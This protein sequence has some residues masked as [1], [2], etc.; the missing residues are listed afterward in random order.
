MTV[1]ILQGK[2]LRFREVGSPQKDIQVGKRGELGRTRVQFH[3]STLFIQ[4]R[5]SCSIGFPPLHP[6]CHMSGPPS[7][8]SVP[9]VTC[10]EVTAFCPCTLQTKCHTA[11]RTDLLM[12]APFFKQTKAYHLTPQRVRCP[13]CLSLLVFQPYTFP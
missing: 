4:F 10:S 2:K 9:A 6:C 7:Y 1:P 3:M 5:A 12:G 11:T 8:T 13:H